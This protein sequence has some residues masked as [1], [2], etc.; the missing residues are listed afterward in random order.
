M[1][2][3]EAKLPNS[4]DPI[5]NPIIDMC[6]TI[7]LS[8]GKTLEFSPFSSVP[9]AKHRA[10]DPYVTPIIRTIE[11]PKSDFMAQSRRELTQFVIYQAG[12]KL[13][14][15]V[16]WSVTIGTIFFLLIWPSIIIIKIL[17]FIIIFIFLFGINNVIK[18][19]FLFGINVDIMGSNSMGTSN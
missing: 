17:F 1:I 12:R 8:A 14:D 13:I 19:I 11:R 9:C 3:S 18:V 15:D 10:A 7:L 6:S 4:Y 5:L 2:V 16:L